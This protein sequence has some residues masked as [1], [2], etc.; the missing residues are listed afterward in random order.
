MKNMY[1]ENGVMMNDFMSDSG[2]S[3]R[4][5]YSPVPTSPYIDA[6]ISPRRLLGVQSSA[7]NSF[8]MPY[9]L[10]GS[11][12][13][14][15]SESP[16]IQRS[17]STRSP[18]SSSIS[19]TLEVGGGGGFQHSGSYKRK[20]KWGRGGGVTRSAK[21]AMWQSNDIDSYRGHIKEMSHD[22]NGCRTLQQCLSDDPQKM[23]PIIYEEVGDSLTE[24]MM[25]SF[26]NY[27]FQKLLDVSSVEQRREVVGA[28]CAD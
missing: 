11:S 5:H 4:A 6:D 7:S 16:R 26:G 8:M 18:P 28:V 14:S 17:I 21:S 20:D 9:L 25:D 23:I 22:H 10:E 13:T 12:L 1:G 24:L 3:P 15:S 27:L 19:S 2:Y